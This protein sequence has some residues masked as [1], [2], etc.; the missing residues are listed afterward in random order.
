MHNALETPENRKTDSFDLSIVVVSWN[1]REILKEC[2]TSIFDGLDGCKAEVFVVDNASSDGSADMVASN[3]PHV[4]LIENSDNLGFA[5]ANNQ[6]IKLASGRH[7]L[8]LNSDTLVLK[9]VLQ[10]SVAYMDG[11][12]DVG[13]MGCRVLNADGS[14]QLTC[15]RYPTLLNLLLLTSGLFRLPRPSFLG[16]YQLRG[17]QRDS[18]REVDTVTGCYMLVRSSAIDDVGL[19]DESF[20]FYGEETD[21]CRRFKDAG[22]PLRFAPVGEIIHYGSLSSRQCNHRRD[23]MLTRGLLQYHRK[24]SGVMA[25]ACAWVLLAVFCLL[26]SIYWG[27]LTALTQSEFAQKRSKHFLG[28]L[29]DFREVWPPRMEGAS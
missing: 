12:P 9:D 28:V 15:S 18:E 19:L 26:R 3:F 22:W 29:R 1:T 17:W 21:W 4:R 7:V 27:S 20:F 24:H 5:K 10:R 2:L 13:V 8:L 6:A 16:R 25:T 23:L 11:H 14:V